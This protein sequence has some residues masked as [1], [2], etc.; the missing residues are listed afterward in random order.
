MANASAVE[1]ASMPS[2]SAVVMWGG[3]NPTPPPSIRWVPG[4]PPE[5]TAD[6]AGSTA[7]RSMAGQ[8]SWST[9]ETPTKQPPT[10]T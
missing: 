7:M 6:S 1:T 4:A 5:R 3:T 10:P 2:S 8:A 9:S